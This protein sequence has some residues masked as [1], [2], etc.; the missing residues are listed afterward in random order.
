MGVAASLYWR[1]INSLQL[2]AH[3]CDW[4]ESDQSCGLPSE[5]QIGSSLHCTMAGTGREW[6]ETD[7]KREEYREQCYQMFMKWKACDPE[8]YN[9]VCSSRRSS[10]ERKSGAVQWISKGGS[11]SRNLVWLEYSYNSFFAK[12]IS[13]RRTRIHQD[14][15]GVMVMKMLYS[16]MKLLR[17][18]QLA[19]TNEGQGAL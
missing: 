3:P 2:L 17:M 8:N 1:F 14:F 18:A 7:Y 12:L 6:I 16:D 19:K 10:K 15:T 13:A 11:A 5:L 4:S 9:Y